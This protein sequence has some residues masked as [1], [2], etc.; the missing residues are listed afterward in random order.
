M[1]EQRESKALGK[2]GQENNPPQKDFFPLVATYH[3]REKKITCTYFFLLLKHLNRLYRIRSCYMHVAHIRSH[4]AHTFFFF[5]T[6]LLPPQ[7][8]NTSG[9]RAP[10]M[11][12]PRNSQASGQ[13]SQPARRPACPGLRDRAAAGTPKP[14]QCTRI[15]TTNKP[16]YFS[17]SR[18]CLSSSFMDGMVYPLR[19]G[20]W[21]NRWFG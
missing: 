4:R 5:Y 17:F 18:P 3:K 19:G 20:P 10:P 7:T 6:A 15:R 14:N 13:R 1:G 16:F 2:V 8:S 12:P 11:I 9:A 21:P